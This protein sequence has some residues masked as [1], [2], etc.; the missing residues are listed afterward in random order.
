MEN[1]MLSKV[2]LEEKEAELALLQT[3]FEADKEAFTALKA[4]GVQKFEINLSKAIADKG[5]ASKNWLS[6]F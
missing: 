2:A 5:V 1:I 6:K 3:Q 4:T